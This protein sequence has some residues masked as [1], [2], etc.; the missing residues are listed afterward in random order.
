MATD[1]DYKS[2]YDILR[3]DPVIK[4]KKVLINQFG[5]WVPFVP[6]TGD[7]Y[8]LANLI[9]QGAIFI[10]YCGWPMMYAGGGWPWSWRQPN[11]NASRFTK[12]VKVLGKWPRDSYPYMYR[13]DE[14]GY[15]RF[16]PHNEKYRWC[17]PRYLIQGRCINGYIE[18]Y[19]WARGLIANIDI[20]QRGWYVPPDSIVKTKTL[21]LPDKPH[22]VTIRCYSSFGLQHGKGWYFYAYRGRPWYR[23]EGVS[24]QVYAGYI[25][26]AL[27][28]VVAPP[29]TEPGQPP[30]TEPGPAPGCDPGRCPTPRP[31]IS[32]GST[33]PCVGL[34]QQL[35]LQA[36]FNPGP[37][38]CIFGP[39]TES[40]V[41]Q[42]QQARGLAVDGIIG[43]QTWAALAAAPPSIPDNKE[44]CLRQGG[45]WDEASQTCRF[46]GGKPPTP[47]LLYAGIGV[48]ALLA[49]A[50]GYSLVKGSPPEK[51]EE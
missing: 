6:R 33:G 3:A 36:G 13:F 4:T 10:D 8:D 50:A 24:P 5:E 26:G 35:L 17:L 11:V 19:P 7:P 29:P 47:W 30:P 49:A 45:T 38:D 27:T 22:P 32:R 15:L 28:G 39:Q 31:T 1:A 12:F 20:A 42:F 18:G 44:E 2:L 46:E 43:P 16:D 48:V 25:K 51:P 34:A 23:V 40:A 9:A 14:E 41:R 37:V 21:I